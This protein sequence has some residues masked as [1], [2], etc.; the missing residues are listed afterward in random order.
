VG[1]VAVDG[2]LRDGVDVPGGGVGGAR[3][4]RA[5]KNG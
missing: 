5:A 4:G 2:R 1:S 3:N